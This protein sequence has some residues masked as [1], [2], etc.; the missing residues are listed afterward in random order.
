MASFCYLD[1]V[2]IL[3]AHGVVASTENFMAFFITL[4]WVIVG[5]C[6]VLLVPCWYYFATH[7]ATQLAS[8]SRTPISVE[9]W[10]RRRRSDGIVDISAGFFV[11]SARRGSMNVSDRIF[12]LFREKG[13]GAY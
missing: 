7:P 5:A 2:G 13:N 6:L 3:L 1:Y 8:T 11:T 12:T 10:S 4:S 9:G